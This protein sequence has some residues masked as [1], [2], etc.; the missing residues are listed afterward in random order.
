M[1]AATSQP[2]TKKE[3]RGR[4]LDSYKKNKKTEFSISKVRVS[5]SDPVINTVNK[6]LEAIREA[7]NRGR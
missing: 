6:V 5:K 3:L 2:L 7:K 1:K 4:L